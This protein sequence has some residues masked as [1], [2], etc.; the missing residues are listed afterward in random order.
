MSFD[1]GKPEEVGA[2]WA[3]LLGRDIVSEADGVLLPGDDTQL[4]LRFVE[5]AAE[6]SGP[7]PVHL[8]LTST[9]LE[10]QQRTVEAALALGGQHIDIG[11]R[12]DEGHI[13]LADPDDNEFCVIEP[14]NNYLAGCGFLGEATGEGS[15]AVGL[16]WRDALGWPLVWNQGQQTAVQSPAGG[17]K[18]A[19]DV[20]PRPTHYGSRR[21]RLDLTAADPGLEAARLVELGATELHTRDDRIVFAD[22]D[23]SE[24]SVSRG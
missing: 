7:N 14:G 22:P 13:V 23:G 12:P 15:P 8:H 4:G 24:F 21:Q 9:T 17:T 11:Q 18:I 10:E 16:F 6:K 20:R 3:G 2:F 1:A 19:W 5:S